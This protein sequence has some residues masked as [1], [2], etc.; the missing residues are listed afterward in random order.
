MRALLSQHLRWLRVLP[1][2]LVVAC[3]GGDGGPTEPA[4]PDDPD[5]PGTSNPPTAAD[6]PTLSADQVASMQS[7]VLTG[8]P[9]DRE[10]LVAEVADR[11][12]SSPTEEG[13]FILPLVPL[14]SGSYELFIPVHPTDVTGGGPAEIR[15]WG[16]DFV[17]EPAEVTLDPLP[18]APGAFVEMAD[19]LQAL[20]DLRFEQMGT[21]R[22]A[23]LA[24]DWSAELDP[25]L[26]PF[27]IAQTL[28]D[29]PTSDA[30]LRDMLAGSPAFESAFG[31]STPDLE[32]LDGL[33]AAGDLIGLISEAL[34]EARGLAEAAPPRTVS[35]ASPARIVS[36]SSAAE[37]DAEMNEAW[38]AANE[39][40]PNSNTG[41]LLQ[42]Y[43][44]T[45][46]AIGLF[47]GPGGTVVATGLGS[48]LWAYQTYQDGKSKLMPKEF[49]G[50]SMSF[51]VDISVFEEDRPGPGTWSNV[52]VSA[53]SEGWILDRTVI[54]LF[55]Q[56][57]G[58]A[59]A[60]GGW[61]NRVGAEAS[62][63]LDDIFDFVSSQ[64]LSQLPAAEGGFIEIPPEV[65]ADIDVT[66]EP[67]TSGRV[68]GDEAIHLVT[69]TAYDP[70]RVG[71]S[72]LTVETA[73]SH[74][75]SAAPALHREA[76]RV[77]AIEV[78]ILTTATNVQPGEIVE[79]QILVDNAL[80]TSLEWTLSPGASWA[81]G[82]T[83]IGGG[84]WSAQLQTPSDAG[85]F[86]VEVTFESTAEGGARDMP[87]APV[88]RDVLEL[89][90]AQVIVE[91][92]SVFLEPGESQTFA[93]IVLGAQNTDVTWSVTGP[94]PSA[95]IGDG[96]GFVAPET[97]GSYLVTATSVEVPSAEG[98]ANVTVVGQCYWSVTIG[99]T[100]GGSWSGEFA[101]H[102]YPD[103]PIAGSFGLSFSPDGG[104]M[105]GGSGT[106]TSP[107]PT[108]TGTGSW[109]V[110][111]VFSADPH[112]WAASNQENTEA[113]M[114]VAENDGN[115]VSGTASGTAVVTLANGDT[116]SAP[117]DMSFRS[118][119][120]F[121]DE[122][123]GP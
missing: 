43:G 93:A 122:P 54:D 63:L 56:I 45:L 26:Y 6:A 101:T 74:F 98:Y 97:T 32:L 62:D 17:T 72:L 47:T 90:S 29:D 116:E 81:S 8:L 34:T 66:G 88:R 109:D 40:D 82:P 50:G 59:K 123:C 103:G 38:S 3:G 68:V 28:L 112:V 22:E 23:V 67:W 118:N 100:V 113:T 111:F 4:G 36:I 92:S 64:R 37:L 39:I 89:S 52:L 77:D 27:A 71:E 25:G 46:G 2:L 61:V 18:E 78:S 94:D 33:T 19:S 86:P 10:D 5:D 99:G 51:D 41:K 104:T 20:L 60:Y 13:D 70:L 16:D 91:P 9:A 84:A 57:A 106:I 108:S 31:S 7:V 21:T 95:S 114:V 121:G 12:V 1:V 96:G 110:S 119:D 76:I 102:T 49:V 69:A 58:N 44:M 75:G 80:D 107:G 115:A 65:W 105:P 24:A 73:G 35:G 15:V 48:A 42:A 117:F 79:L 55:S 85:D 53:Q 83:D 11:G 120:M 87:G 30:D 14:E